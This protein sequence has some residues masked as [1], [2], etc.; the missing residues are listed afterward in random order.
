MMISISDEQYAAL[1]AAVAAITGD[2]PAEATA[3]QEAVVAAV[4]SAKLAW[5]IQEAIHIE[6]TVNALY[7]YGQLVGGDIE[8]ETLAMQ[9]K[10]ALVKTAL[11]IG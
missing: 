3:L 5:A 9:A 11:G 4:D 10:H 7:E 2:Y 8:T 1:A 6:P